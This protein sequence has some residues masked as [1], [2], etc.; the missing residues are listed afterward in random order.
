MPSIPIVKFKL[1]LGAQKILSTNWK[2][3]VDL[4][5]KIHKPNDKIKVRLVINND[6]VFNKFLFQDGVTK[7]NITPIKGN[8]NK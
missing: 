5:N 7:S 3:P 4:S 1:R 2:F 8:N 6:I